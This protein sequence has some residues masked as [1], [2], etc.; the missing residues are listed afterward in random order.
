MCDKPDPQDAWSM[1]SSCVNLIS[2]VLP[3]IKAFSLSPI[4]FQCEQVIAVKDPLACVKGRF[5]I[6]AVDP[7]PVVTTK[8]SV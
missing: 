2:F 5:C 3:K 7:A 8:F 6:D 4:P 1:L